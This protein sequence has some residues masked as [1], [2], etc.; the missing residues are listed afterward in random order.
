MSF[1]FI[2]TMFKHFVHKI[3]V[4]KF[5]YFIKIAK[6][7]P[8]N[9]SSCLKFSWSSNRKSSGSKNFLSPSLLSQLLRC[10]CQHTPSLRPVVVHKY[11][12]ISASS[13]GYK[14]V[15]SADVAHEGNVPEGAGDIVP[16]G[17][18]SAT[19]QSNSG[20]S[21]GFDSDNSS[22]D[23]PAEGAA[24]DT[25]GE[26]A[27]TC[28]TGSDSFPKTDD[29]QLVLGASDEQEAVVR[30]NFEKLEKLYI[31]DERN[32]NCNG[33]KHDKLEGVRKNITAEIEER[34]ARETRIIYVE[35]EENEQQLMT[36]PV[37]NSGATIYQRYELQEAMRSPWY[38]GNMLSATPGRERESET[39]F[40]HVYIQNELAASQG[41]EQFGATACRGYE[42]HGATVTLDEQY[43]AATTR[44]SKQHGAASQKREKDAKTVPKEHHR[45]G[46]IASLKSQEQ[47]IWESLGCEKHTDVPSPEYERYGVDDITMDQEVAELRGKK[48]QG[49]EALQRKLSKFQDKVE[50]EEKGTTKL[51]EREGKENEGKKSTT[52]TRK[53]ENPVMKPLKYEEENNEHEDVI[54]HFS[55]F[56]PTLPFVDL[57]PCPIYEG[58]SKNTKE[59]EG[60]CRQY[61]LF[62]S[63]SS[64]GGQRPEPEKVSKT[65]FQLT[66]LILFVLLEFQF[67]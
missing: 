63:L 48:L 55:L 61:P 29:E 16:T 18:K 24:R 51:S 25:D 50:E 62:G 35:A 6:K 49:E 21:S 34:R 58:Q 59:T 42:Q 56:S 20:E 5:N 44:G 67:S 46:G 7:N 11:C 10:F 47:G 19:L 2:Y 60:E 14:S 33:G 12:P 30:K 36:L 23:T 54:N 26:T 4:F 13:I 65:V 22:S 8:Q 27:S 40:H 64:K 32:I 39:A 31:Y 45:R 37:G 15:V 66:E 53:E 28:E 38:A 41:C 3:T 52:K 57:R 43:S 9:I 17:G 1:T